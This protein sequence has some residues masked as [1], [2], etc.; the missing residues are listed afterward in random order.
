[1]AAV[2]WPAGF[3]FSIFST[4]ISR[5]W[6]LALIL[7]DEPLTNQILCSCVALHDMLPIC[8]TLSKMTSH[9]CSV[10]PGWVRK[11]KLVV[12]GLEAG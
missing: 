5:F 6:Q 2:T 9:L 12:S 7:L 3:C 10:W 11:L 1:M 8:T 4:G